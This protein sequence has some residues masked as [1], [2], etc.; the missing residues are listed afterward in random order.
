M[1]QIE[2]V[3]F[4]KYMFIKLFLEKLISTYSERVVTACKG[5]IAVWS[6]DSGFYEFIYFNLYKFI[7]LY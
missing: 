6:V 4:W 2:I 7:F 1:A 5:V 3:N